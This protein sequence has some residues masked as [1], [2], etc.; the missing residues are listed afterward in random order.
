MGAGLTLVGN[1]AHQ[2]RLL[3][4][5]RYRVA[6]QLPL[7]QCIKIAKVLQHQIAQPCSH[8]GR[9][10][11]RKSIAPLDT[12]PQDFA[13]AHRSQAPASAFRRVG[14]GFRAKSAA[15]TD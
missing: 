15:C 5:V 10:D 4:P 6:R 9:E 8:C 11:S 13:P 1:A 12:E 2:D 7:L 14:R 3:K